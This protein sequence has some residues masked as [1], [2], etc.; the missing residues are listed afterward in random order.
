MSLVR[1]LRGYVCGSFGILL[2]AGTALDEAETPTGS[3][4]TNSTET[5]SIDMSA[6]R[7]STRAWWSGFASTATCGR[8]TSEREKS[9]RSRCRNGQR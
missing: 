5:S 1:S 4:G 9:I 7:T 3:I 6:I 2:L 8:Y